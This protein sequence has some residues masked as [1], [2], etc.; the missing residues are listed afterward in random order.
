MPWDLNLPYFV[1]ISMVLQVNLEVVGLLVMHA[2]DASSFDTF[3]ST[4]MCEPGTAEFVKN[5]NALASTN[6]LSSLGATGRPPSE[7]SYNSAQMS[8][9]SEWG[10][11]QDE[12]ITSDDED[13]TM[14]S[15]FSSLP[16]AQ[17]L[18]ILEKM[19]FRVQDMRRHFV[20]D[21]SQTLRKIREGQSVPPSKEDDANARTFEAGVHAVLES[22]DEFLLRASEHFR[23][24]CEVMMRSAGSVT[25]VEEQLYVLQQDHTSLRTHLGD[26]T[27]QSTP[28]A[29]P[30]LSDISWASTPRSARGS[31]GRIVRQGSTVNSED[32]FYDANASA[33]N[34]TATSHT[35]S[36]YE[37]PRN[38]HPFSAPESPIPRTDA[39]RTENSSSHHAKVSSSPAS[40]PITPVAGSPDRAL[41]VTSPGTTT[42]P[43]SANAEGRDPASAEEEKE[44]NLA[45]LSRLKD[46]QLSNVSN[47]STSSNAVPAEMQA[48]ISCPTYQLTNGSPTNWIQHISRHRESS[49][50]ADDL[51]NK[52]AQVE[53]SG[54]T[55]AEEAVLAS[56]MRLLSVRQKESLT[57]RDIYQ[58]IRGY[59]SAKDRLGE[60]SVAARKI[61]VFRDENNFGKI[62]QIKL[63]RDSYF[64]N[65]WQETI[66]GID[67]F[68]HP[69]IGIDVSKVNI[70]GILTF[71]EPQLTR[72]VCQKMAAYRSY[73]E[74]LSSEYGN[75]R[76]KVSYLIDMTG[77]GMSAFVGDKKTTMKK[78]FDIGGA[79]FPESVWK[80]YLINTPF[81]VRMGWSVVKSMVHPVTQVCIAYHV[82]DCYPR[83]WLHMADHLSKI[84]FSGSCFGMPTG[85]IAISV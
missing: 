59:E 30:R 75:Q 37:T 23:D 6:S 55:A 61:A 42:P 79:Y 54:L 80:I 63:D 48:L 34:G 11:A 44:E 78:I 66:Y 19:L 20:K 32:V 21:S 39:H 81:A 12:S 68:G 45:P 85:C 46:R 28:K 5:T 24:S 41:L 47:I 53:S 9:V 73:L 77:A 2:V 38:T 62:L 56:T 35:G 15:L 13:G 22:T 83:L 7:A 69:L 65:V 67:R 50:S 25:A 3:A 14:S 29:E 27:E 40:N 82:C 10:D 76:Y 33:L 51:D 71:P 84:S 64:H 36:A 8:E 17:E 72:L 43:K 16:Q 74:Y 60:T 31:Q 57:R 4:C 70:D 26:N 49:S 18:V 1:P 52:L 58:I